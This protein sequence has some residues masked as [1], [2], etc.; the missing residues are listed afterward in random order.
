MQLCL[1][2]NTTKP[3]NLDQHVL[4]FPERPNSPPEEQFQYPS[5]PLLVIAEVRPQELAVQPEAE[6]R[7]LARQEDRLL[8]QEMGRRHVRCQGHGT[9]AHADA[10]HPL[11]DSPR[12]GLAAARGVEEADQV[13]RCAALDVQPLGLTDSPVRVLV[14]QEVDDRYVSTEFPQVTDGLGVVELVGV[15]V[16]RIEDN[17]DLAPLEILSVKCLQNESQQL[18]RRRA[19]KAI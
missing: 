18:M 2:A 19:P 8:Q 14:A 3:L 16:G 5:Q 4:S 9:G 11:A 10:E 13:G 6:G 12:D 17:A 7:L 1:L 15:T